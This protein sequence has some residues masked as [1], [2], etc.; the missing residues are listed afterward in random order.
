[1]MFQVSLAAYASEVVPDWLRP[2]GLTLAH[3]RLH[4]APFEL[5]AA[6]THGTVAT[7]LQPPCGA[8]RDLDGPGDC[9]AA[10][11]GCHDEAGGGDGRV[12]HR[13][14]E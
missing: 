3:R 7:A 4:A 10:R 11:R 12:T 1:M 6:V 8:P 14:G 5:G 2:L 13:F 9:I